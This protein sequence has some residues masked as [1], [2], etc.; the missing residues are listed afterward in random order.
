[1][2]YSLSDDTE[3]QQKGLV[4]ITWPGNKQISSIPDPSDLE[5]IKKVIDGIP[6]R[7]C[8]T[9]FCLPDRPY[10][11]LIRS[12]FAVSM[13][14]NHKGRLKFHIGT[15]NTILTANYYIYC[16]SALVLDST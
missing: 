1:M 3:S 7:I 10:F 11:H 14:A 4:H 2:M 16:V 12:M 9:H 6:I 8:A 13:A 15:Y 5:T